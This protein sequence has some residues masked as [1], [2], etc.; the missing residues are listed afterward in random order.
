MSRSEDSGQM[1]QKARE[2]FQRHCEY[3]S[4]K[5][6]R[7]LTDLLIQ[8]HGLDPLGIPPDSPEAEALRLTLITALH[9]DY[10]PAGSLASGPAAYFTRLIQYA[11]LHYSPS[12]KVPMP[13]AAEEN[14]ISALLDSLL[15]RP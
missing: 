6:V 15:H 9:R 12:A 1:Y 14:E 10:H 8:K 13:P 11:A 3:R 5:S 2:A 4:C 7:I